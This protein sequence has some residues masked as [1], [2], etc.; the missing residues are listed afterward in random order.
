MAKAFKTLLALPG[1]DEEKTD[2]Q[3]ITALARG[4]EVLRAFEPGDGVLGNL[5][6]AERTRLPK[7]TIARITHTLTTLGYLEYNRRLEKY[8]LGTP[9]LSLGYACLSNVGLRRVARPHM[10]ELA[11]HANVS[12]ALASRDRL[13]L[14]YLE[15]VHG[16]ATVSLRLDVGTRVPIQHSAI[17]MAYLHALPQTE[18]DFLVDAIRK[19]DEKEFPKFRKRLGIAFKEIDNTGFC[20]GLGLYERTVNG[21]ATALKTRD[22]GQVYGFNCS[23]PAFQIGEE[24]LRADVGPRLVATVRNI[25][26]DLLRHPFMA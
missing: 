6:I 25:E 4:L 15:L 12:V 11:D 14:T 24:A 18:R 8:A 5:E 3:F 21:V 10:Q 16:S 22:G 13:N 9:T 19:R 26:A 2:R 17:G 7:P 23:G 1:P 20:V